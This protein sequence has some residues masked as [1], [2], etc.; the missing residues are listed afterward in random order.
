MWHVID[1]GIFP[2]YFLYDYNIHNLTCLFHYKVFYT[3]IDG[4]SVPSR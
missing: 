4:M 3:E 2:L 1:F